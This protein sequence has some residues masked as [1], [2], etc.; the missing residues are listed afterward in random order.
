MADVDPLRDRVQAA[1]PP[2]EP[3][4]VERALAQLHGSA[5]TR[6]HSRHAARWW[7]PVAVA[8]ATAVTVTALLLVNGSAGRKGTPPAHH[9]VTGTWF[10]HATATVTTPKGRVTIGDIVLVHLD[11][12]DHGRIE[13]RGPE[14]AGSAALTRVGSGLW[15]TNALP[16]YCGTTPGTYRVDITDQAVTLTAVGDTCAARRA[17]LDNAVFARL[18]KDDQ[19]TG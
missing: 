1:F 19:L 16:R 18:V 3:V 9:G 5:P 2:V 13:F 11:S 7:A 8:L 12:T 14:R 6:R 15:Q 17:V 4:A 10:R